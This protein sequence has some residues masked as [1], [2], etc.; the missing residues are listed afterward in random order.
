MTVYYGSN[1]VSS[2]APAAIL[3]IVDSWFWYPKIS[4]LLA[5]VSAAIK[6]DY[7]NIMALGYLGAKLE[8]YVNGQYAKDFARELSPG[9]LQYYSA[10][11][12]SV[13]GNDA[14][15]WGLCLKDECGAETAAS[16]CMD[17]SGLTARMTDLSGWLLSMIGEIHSAFDNANLRHPDI[18]IH[19]STTHSTWGLK[20][21]GRIPLAP[22]ASCHRCRTSQTMCSKEIARLPDALARTFASSIRLNRIYVI[23][24]QG[25]LDDVDWD[26]EL[27]QWR[28]ISQTCP[29]P[30]L[31]VLSELTTVNNSLHGP[32][33]LAIRSTSPSA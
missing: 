1:Q 17:Q 11:L 23:Q 29:W 30:W 7:S 21:P 4:N 19:C 9:F 10:V 22:V 13:G 15:D 33:L 24:S 28:R 12:I 16:G 31:D 32:R 20:A 5:E 25:T 3:A 27:H 26:N 8:E 14:V 18:F 2:G 6:A